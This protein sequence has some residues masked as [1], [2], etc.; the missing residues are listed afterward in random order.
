MRVV[1]RVIRP[2]VFKD[3]GPA[4]AVFARAFA[5]D[6]LY[7]WI[8]PDERVRGRR[9]PRLFAAELRAAQRGRDEIDLMV[10]GGQILGCSLWSPPGALRPSARQQLAVLASFPLI[11]GRRLP[12]ALSSF[13]AIGAARPRE[14]HWYLST[15]GVD[16]PAQ[17]TGVARGLLAP[18]LARCD[19]AGIPAALV[20]GERSN[21]A[22]Y[23]SLGFAV[24]GEITLADGGPPHWAM[25]RR[26]RE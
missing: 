16:P 6:P 5:G 23:E 4:A 25:W 19:E 1:D 14:P 21:V 20:T 26:P 11:L 2:A 22:Y 7:A 8:F 18:R 15:I 13:N 12:V 17:R 10:A 24:T 3:T 9:L